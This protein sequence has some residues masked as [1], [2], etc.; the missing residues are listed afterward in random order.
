MIEKR[1]GVSTKNVSP[2]VFRENFPINSFFINIQQVIRILL[3]LFRELLP[4]SFLAFRH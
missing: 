2:P 1:S 4:F 3:L